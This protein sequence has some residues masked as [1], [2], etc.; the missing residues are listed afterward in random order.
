MELEEFID[1]LQTTTEE[2][3]S[4]RCGA[5]DNWPV[6]LDCDFSKAIELIETSEDFRLITHDDAGEGYEQ[7]S[8]YYYKDKVISIGVLD[9]VERSL[10]IMYGID[11][12]KYRTQ[13]MVHRNRLELREKAGSLRDSADAMIGIANIILDNNVSACFVRTHNKDRTTNRIYHDINSKE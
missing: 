12:S 3:L 5:G 7:N 4:D 2:E 10:G 11:T 6:L 1:R 9:G 8:I 13:Y